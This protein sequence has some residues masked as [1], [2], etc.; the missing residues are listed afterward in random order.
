MQDEMRNA[1]IE[2]TKRDIKKSK[3]IEFV[4]PEYKLVLGDCVEEIGYIER[5]SVD[6]SIF[7][8][9]FSSLFVYSA[10]D[11]DMGN[12]IDDRQFFQHM[13]FLTNHLWRVLRS[14]RLLSF[15]CMNLPTSK[16]K[17]GFIGIKDF[18]GDL[19][20][21]F[22][23]AGF[24]YHS[25]VCIWKDPVTAMQRT[26]ALGLLHKQIVKDSS[27]SRQGIADYLVTMRKPGENQ[28]RISGQLEYY[29][30]DQSD[31]D[32]TRWCREKF[33]AQKEFTDREPMDFATFK[34]IQIWQRYASPIWSDINPSNTLQ[35]RSAR[36][37][38][39][40]R[41]IAPLQL[42]VIERALQL[43]TMPDDLVLSP[44]AGIGSEGHEAV[45][46]GRRFLGLELKKSYWEQ[47]CRNLEYAEQHADAQGS[48]LL[49]VQSGQAEEDPGKW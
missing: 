12:S 17:D 38:A 1:I 18:R 36:Q 25:E 16:E 31:E 14:G 39:D 40:E 34:S 11:R 45:R 30:G 27:M 4:T 48:L 23:K 42:Q 21:M 9:P 15:H 20:R 2:N 19:I 43:W 33:D 49:A 26:K 35:Y 13:E 7:S 41:H 22:Q 8:P 44:F 3:R 6:Y 37:D 29:A 28:K 32:F 5:E 47:A 24:L 10:S 46:K